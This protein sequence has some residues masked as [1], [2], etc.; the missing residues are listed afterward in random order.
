MEL[1]A[2]GLRARQRFR[3]QGS[4]RPRRGVHDLIR[5]NYARPHG[6]FLTTRWLIT[7]QRRRW[8]IGGYFCY[9]NDVG[10]GFCGFK[11]ED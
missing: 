5:S 11:G 7:N 3:R 6:K 4:R 2:G 1:A 10:L 8:T 9:H